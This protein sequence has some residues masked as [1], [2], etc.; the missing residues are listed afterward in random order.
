MRKLRA[1]SVD[2]WDIPRQGVFNLLLK[3]LFEQ[4]DLQRAI[5]TLEKR[6]GIIMLKYPDHG[7]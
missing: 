4:L 2:H 3:L 6:T 7:G 1:K 5:P